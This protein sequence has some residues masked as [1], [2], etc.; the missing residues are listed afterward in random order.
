MTIKYSAI[1]DG[2]IHFEIGGK[3]ITPSI[4]LAKTP[5]E[6]ITLLPL[7][8]NLTLPKGKFVLRLVIDNGN[9]NLDSVSM[10]YAIHNDDKKPDILNIR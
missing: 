7:H 3:P 6:K 8:K 1:R 9:M 5:S 2:A 10:R 4:L